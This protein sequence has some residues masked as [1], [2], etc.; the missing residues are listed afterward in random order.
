MCVV[1]A[2]TAVGV[3]ALQSQIA[4]R[5]LDSTAKAVMILS[6]VV[7]DRSLTLNDITGGI[8]PTNRSKLDGDMILLKDRGHIIA[9]AIW[10]LSDG[11][12]VYADV[13]NTAE[14]TLSPGLVAQARAGEPFAGPDADHAGAALEI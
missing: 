7:I 8:H 3:W 9:L 1:V 6:S 12:L 14:G 11:G 4:S 5:T 10:S 2:L 13:D